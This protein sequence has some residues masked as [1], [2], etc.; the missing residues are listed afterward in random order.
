MLFSIRRFRRSV[1]VW[2]L[3]VV[4][5]QLSWTA[6]LKAQSVSERAHVIAALISLYGPPK[7]GPQA[8]DLANGYKLSPVFSD[9]GLLVELVVEPKAGFDPSKPNY[10][11][12]DQFDLVFAQI[13]S[14]KALGK[15]LEQGPGF[16]SGGRIG[17]SFQY[18]HGYLNTV[19][20]LTHP[21]P[22]PISVAHIYYLHP[23]TGIARIPGAPMPNDA[24]PFGLVCIN[25]KAYIAPK[26]EFLKLW[27][28][29]NQA[30]TLT[31]AGPTGDSCSV[32]P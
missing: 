1:I 29:R 18:E 20:P 17:I 27:A 10:L 3:A 9:A 13:N 22:R 4:A 21:R 16:A 19:E 26:E 28:K 2:G 15:L 8:F 31:V 14:V 24:S 23:V 5:F 25:G 11:T 6:S 12:R 32:S 7:G 30:Q